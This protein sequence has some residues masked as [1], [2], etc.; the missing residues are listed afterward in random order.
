MPSLFQV[1]EE[2]LGELER[3]LPQLAEALSPSLDNRTRMKLRRVQSI[4]SAIRWNYGPHTGTTVIPADGDA[5]Q[6]S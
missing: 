6:I 2:D 3:V 1:H 4:L 5:D